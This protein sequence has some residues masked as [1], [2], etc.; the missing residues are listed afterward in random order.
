MKLWIVAE[1]KSFDTRGW[2]L[3][4]EFAGAFATREEAAG[5]CTRPGL[6]LFS[7]ELGVFVGGGDTMPA[8]DLAFPS[9]TG[10][11]HG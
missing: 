7:A 2:A 3:D 6:C 4:W 5:V 1:V 9:G 11:T 10:Q 8:P